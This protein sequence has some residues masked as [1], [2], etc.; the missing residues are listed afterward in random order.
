MISVLEWRNKT[1]FFSYFLFLICSQGKYK[2]S[3]ILCI[4]SDE[5]L[6]LEVIFILYTNCVKKFDLQWRNF[7]FLQLFITDIFVKSNFVYNWNHCR[8]V[9]EKMLMR[10]LLLSLMICLI[11]YNPIVVFP[12]Q[13]MCLTDLLIRKWR[14]LLKQISSSLIPLVQV[15]SP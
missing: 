10:V 3:R 7:N 13:M 15:S 8:L 9:V 1:F 4:L 6:L 11:A 12:P 5:K 14:F 2:T